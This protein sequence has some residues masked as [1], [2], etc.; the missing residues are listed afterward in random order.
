MEDG[1]KALLRNLKLTLLILDG[2]SKSRNMSM[3]LLNGTRLG[4]LPKASN[5]GMDLITKIYLVLMS[6]QLLSGFC[7]HWLLLVDGIF[8]SWMF[9]MLFCMVS[10]RKKYIC[11]SLLDLLIT[12]VP[13][14]YVAWR[15]RYMCLSKLRML[16]MLV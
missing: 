2:S 14:I 5:K 12:L 1:F 10:W 11:L 4:W 13:S 7:F 6:N 16:V 15:R 9:R 8:A 3:V